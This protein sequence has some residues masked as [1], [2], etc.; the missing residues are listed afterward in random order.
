M[1]KKGKHPRRI[2]FAERERGI[3]VQN[4]YQSMGGG[5]AVWCDSRRKLYVSSHKSVMCGVMLQRKE[6]GTAKQKPPQDGS[7]LRR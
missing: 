5:S 3:R 7:I 6:G 1:V 4:G 2:K